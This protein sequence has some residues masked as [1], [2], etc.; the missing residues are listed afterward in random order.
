MLAHPDKTKERFKRDAE[1]RLLSFTDPL[2]RR[3]RWDY[4]EAGLL[5]Q[6]HNANDTTLT[7]HW[8]KLGQLVRLRNE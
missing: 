7:Y 2:N 1:G 6:R 4:N 8:D 5:H 3:T